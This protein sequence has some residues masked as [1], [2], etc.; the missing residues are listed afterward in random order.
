MEV[1]SITP[2]G[3]IPSQSMI[4]A[5][6]NF[7][8]PGTITDTRS[9]FGL[10][11]QVA[12]AYSL[13]P[14]M[15]ETLSNKKLQICLDAFKDSQRVIID[16][17]QKGVATF[18]KDPVTC[19]APD[20]SKEG[21]GFLLLQKHCQC[22]IEKA[23]ICCPDGWCLIFADSRFCTD[24]EHRYAPIEGEA[25]AIVW[26]LE[27]C[28]MFIKSSPNVIVVTDH[29]PLKGLFGDHDL[30]KIQNPRLF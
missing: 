4:Q 24:A 25:A 11:S 5:I 29:K 8:V 23:L 26:A 27:K 22:T 1:S 14:V 3:V 18:D 7:P 12:W 28:C 2:S 30:N 19:L 17:V 20:W 10:I 15:W 6:L 13:G 21:M 9:W 16:L